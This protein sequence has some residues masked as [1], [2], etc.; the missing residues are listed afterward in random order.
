MNELLYTIVDILM[1]ILT[2]LT[3]AIVIQAVL[4][5]IR[6]DPN[7]FFVRLLNKIT[8]PIL[9]PLGRVIPPIAGLDFTPAIAIAIL[10]LAQNLIPGLLLP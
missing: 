5:W 8:D 4:S 10:L 6:P 9:G 3:Y 2:L 7:N 1:M